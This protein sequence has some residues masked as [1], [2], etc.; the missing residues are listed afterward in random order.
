LKENKMAVE[1][2]FHTQEP[3]IEFVEKCVDSGV[4]LCLSSDSHNMY[5][6]GELWPHL[7]LLEK[8]GVKADD[9]GRVLLQ[10]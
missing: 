9:L 1:M 8:I 10:G 3:D 4:K 5:E 7:K 6:L 2:N